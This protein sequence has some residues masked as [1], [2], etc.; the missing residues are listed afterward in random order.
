MFFI[1]W[2]G[3][4]ENLFACYDL[5]ERRDRRTSTPHVKSQG[6]QTHALMLRSWWGPLGCGDGKGSQ[7]PHR[8]PFHAPARLETPRP[9]DA[10]S[11]VPSILLRVRASPRA[12]S[13]PNPCSCIK[14]RGRGR[15]LGSLTFFFL[16]TFLVLLCLHVPA[17]LRLRP[18]VLQ[19]LPRSPTV[20]FPASTA[21]SHASSSSALHQ[22]QR[23]IVSDAHLEVLVARG[24]L[25]PH[26]ADAEWL[27]PLPG[28]RSPSPP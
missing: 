24:L 25:P 11:R 16:A 3:D 27:A 7:S 17:A 26:I 9:L 13:R 20:V 14:E 2:Y 5:T 15:L 10:R 22:W 12:S 1:V 23:S 18:P 19:V 8:S 28:E 21:M 4:T 6:G